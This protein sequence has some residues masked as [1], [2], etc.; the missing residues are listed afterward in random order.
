MKVIFFGPP[1]AGKGTI[2]QH[3]KEDLGIPQISTGDLLRAEVK[4]GSELG[5]KAKAYMDKGALVTDELVVG[6][7][8]CRIEQE[9]CKKGY[10]LD[11]FPRTIPQA[12]ALENAGIKIDKVLNFKVDDSLVIRRI[13]GR[14]MSKSTGKIYNIYPECAPHPPAG[15]PEGDLLQ[16]EDD[17][18]EVVRKRLEQ[19]KRDTA[20]LIGFYQERNILVDIKADDPLD[21]IVK[22][23]RNV[24]S[25]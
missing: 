4:S 15:L 24:L 12:E 21:V 25:S 3:V 8:K 18:E 9:D 11:G 17:N 10:I 14:R 23:V 13:T 1:G 6:M 7:L 19:Y 16:R 2:A 22:N 20:P 5:M